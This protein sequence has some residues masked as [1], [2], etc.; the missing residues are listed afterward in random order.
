MQQHYWAN[1]MGHKERND[2]MY[3]AVRS[4]SR[5]STGAAGPAFQLKSESL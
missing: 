2:F 3:N 4:Q 5:H 1:T